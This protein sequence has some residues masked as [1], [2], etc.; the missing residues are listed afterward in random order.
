MCQASRKAHVELGND[1]DTLNE[2]TAYLR[3]AHGLI[4][5]MFSYTFAPSIEPDFGD[6]HDYVPANPYHRS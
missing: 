1:V 5:A 4:Q 6:A 3:S 2:F